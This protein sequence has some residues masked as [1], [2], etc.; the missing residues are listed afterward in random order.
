M[1]I[2]M[3]ILDCEMALLTPLL[4]KRENYFKHTVIHLKSDH[5]IECLFRE[6]V[7]RAVSE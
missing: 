1:K 4:R 2:T 3:D 5:Y 7:Y 6:A